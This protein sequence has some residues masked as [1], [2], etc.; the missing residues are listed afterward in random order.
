MVR[1]EGEEET[2]SSE[3]GIEE[4][5]TRYIV[6]N[7]DPELEEELAQQLKEFG[8]EVEKHSSDE[9]K[10][11]DEK[12]ED[13]KP[14]CVEKDKSPKHGKEM[15]LSKEQ[16]EKKEEDK[17]KEEAESIRKIPEV[18]HHEEH[19]PKQEEEK[20]TSE[21]EDN[22]REHTTTES[23]R[24]EIVFIQDSDE[25][26]EEKIGHETLV[27]RRIEIQHIQEEE[28]DHESMKGESHIP[29]WLEK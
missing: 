25:E 18:E 14:P 20:K 1:E 11:I 17:P 10:N 5:D 12:M 6:E 26:E 4:P 29:K 15:P 22:P 24:K 7:F 3:E 27:G 8:E 2:Q 13:T 23:P 16:E 9:E 19:G 28:G 21:G